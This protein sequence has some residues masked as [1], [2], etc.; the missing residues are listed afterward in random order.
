M[1]E[2]YQRIR[3]L[4][5]P[6]LSKVK[7][8][9]YVLHTETVTLAMELILE[10]EK[11]N[12]DILIPAALCHDLGWYD[13]PLKYQKPILSK[14]D[15][16]EGLKLHI[17][18]NPSLTRNVLDQ[19]GYSKNKIEKI[20]EII[21]AHKFVEPDTLEKKL[22]IDADTLS[23]VFKDQLYADAKA[24][25]RTPREMLEFRSQNKYHTQTANEIFQRELKSRER[26]IN[27][28]K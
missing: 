7:R 17:K 2:I 26:E 9:N 11:G 27:G 13:V 12:P 21:Q 22:L 14:E 3:D 10:K 28:K 16:I 20:I 5:I 24:Y 1:K 25:Q 23:D 8:K 18:Y 6:Y 15:K 19:V 4:A